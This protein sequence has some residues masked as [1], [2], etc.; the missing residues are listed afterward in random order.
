MNI[1]RNRA[2]VGILLIAVLL[3]G[4]NTID[5]MVG[6]ALGS[7]VSSQVGG[8]SGRADSAP[9]SSDSESPFGTGNGSL[10][11]LP[12]GAGFQIIHAQTT[13][14]QGF[15][16]ETANF[17]PGEGVRWRLVWSDD[18]EMD[19]AEAED[20]AFTEHALLAETAEGAWWY[21]RMETDEYWVEYEY[22][23]QPDGM[24]VEL[25]YQD[26]E[27]SES[28]T[29][30]VTVNLGVYQ[31]DEEYTTFYDALEADDSGEYDVR[32][33]SERISVPAGTFDT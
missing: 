7:A 13:F 24:V 31:E 17:E 11:M 9:E 23:L 28:R 12:P 30:Q 14:F 25:N 4:C 18:D 10:M 21:V 6:E 16:E 8:S 3:T 5:S 15:S 32:R 27:M 1:R 19:D 29:A 2:L 20:E 22:F 33:S 26:S